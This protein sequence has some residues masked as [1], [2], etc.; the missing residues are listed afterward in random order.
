MK[1]DL[2]ENISE[3]I[4]WKGANLMLATLLVW[5]HFALVYD[6]LK[7][8]STSTSIFKALGVFLRA[9]SIKRPNGFRTNGSNFYFKSWHLKQRVISSL[10][11]LKENLDVECCNFNCSSDSEKGGDLLKWWWP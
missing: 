5:P 3:R 8:I 11:A 6:K 2:M 7:L 1:L 4:S 10:L 9:K